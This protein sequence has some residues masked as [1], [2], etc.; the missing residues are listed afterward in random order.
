MG[1]SALSGG[2]LTTD[3][4]LQVYGSPAMDDYGRD[5]A[6]AYWLPHW[7]YDADDAP[8]VFVAWR[9]AEALPLGAR[10]RSRYLWLHDEVCAAPRRGLAPPQSTRLR[11]L[12]GRCTGTPCRA[13]RS[14]SCRAQRPTPRCSSSRTSTPP[15]RVIPRTRPRECAIE[16][17]PAANPTQLPEHARPYAHITSNGLDG[18]AL[19]DGPNAADRFIYASTPSA[20]LELLLAMWPQVG[21]VGSER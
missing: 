17:V 4:T 3:W 20:G 7:A 19:A 5:R 14:L 10:A 21:R 15:R 9:F 16:P 12:H 13:A 11:A 8:E 1:R 6:G 18:T 2:G